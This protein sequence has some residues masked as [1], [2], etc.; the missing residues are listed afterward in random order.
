LDGLSRLVFGWLLRFTAQV[1][2]DFPWQAKIE[3]IA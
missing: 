2:Y 1:G 3:S